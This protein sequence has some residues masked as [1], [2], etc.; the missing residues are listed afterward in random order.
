M[1]LDFFQ[2][3]LAELE[4]SDI[5]ELVRNKIPES[6]DLDYKEDYPKDNNK[7]AKLMIAF[8]NSLGGY[9]I[10][11]IKCGVNI[12]RPVDI[13]G[14]DKQEHS[15]K[16]TQIALS[17]SQPKIWPQVKV[18][19]HG[20][21][22]HKDI[23]VI[24]VNEAIE[25]IMYF[26]RNDKDSNK[27]Y[28]RINDKIEPADQ[29]LLKK[30]FS[31]RNISEEIEQ[32]FKKI[33]EYHKEKF[34]IIA[35]GDPTHRYISIASISIPFSRD[36]TIIDI[37]NKETE[38][39][40][41]SLHNS[42]GFDLKKRL[43]NFGDYI[44]DFNYMGTYFKSDYLYKTNDRKRVSEFQIYANGIVTGDIIYLARQGQDL[45]L[46]LVNGYE[47]LG[48]D[49]ATAQYSAFLFYEN[50][51]ALI[52][53]YLQ[54]FKMIYKNFFTGKIFTSLRFMTKEYRIF[55]NLGYDY[56]VFSNS[57][58]FSLIKTIYIRDLDD[59]NKFKGIINDFLIDILRF[60]G[61]HLEK[62]EKSIGI[63]Q[64]T[65]ERYLNSVFR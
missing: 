11:G 33:N 17:Y 14:V 8:A 44:R 42:I 26:S 56:F 12:N 3:D 24:K 57:N 50:I 2:K 39:F 31:K 1:S 59:R 29:A 62:A 20:R 58:D 38:R 45:K 10:I 19:S 40:I 46:E 41:N 15:T 43:G 37:N 36:R 28:I 53:L 5:Q 21:D 55:I 30:L 13:N 47:D 18:I 35:Q 48:V 52:I 60:F 32:H 6:Y 4:F 61:F 16:I 49:K 54:L 63:F 7:L 27:F 9:I 23:V 51:P 65:L 34:Q 64:D 25:P 22:N